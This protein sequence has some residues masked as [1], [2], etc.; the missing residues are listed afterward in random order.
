MQLHSIQPK[1]A[2]QDK[3]RVGRG[4]KRGTTSGRGTKGQNARS[5]SKKIRPAIYD[6]I[7]KLP[8]LRGWK[9]KRINETPVAVRL[10]VLARVFEEGTIITKEALAEKKVIRKQGGLLPK[11]KILAGSPITKK[12]TIEGMMLTKG[13]LEAVTKAGGS[14]KQAAGQSV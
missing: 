13:A 5:G 3:K 4:G 1:K 7:K 14:V 11:V 10:E 9:M 12:L 6:L 8:K 2:W